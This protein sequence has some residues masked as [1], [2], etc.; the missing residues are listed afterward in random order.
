MAPFT[1]SN[2]SDT[3]PTEVDRLIVENYDG[4]KLKLASNSVTTIMINSTK[5]KIAVDVSQCYLL[6]TIYCERG[7][8]C[9][10]KVPPN[11]EM[12]EASFNPI[13]KLDITNCL[14]LSRLYLDSTHIKH[15]DFT[16]CI[17][18][19]SLVSRNSRLERVINLDSPNMIYIN[20]SYSKL[21][22]I[23]LSR[24]ENLSIL[25][26]NHTRITKLYLD[27]CYGLNKLTMTGTHP[28]CFT[29]PFTVKDVWY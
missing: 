13:K 7:T 28:S 17:H 18:I 4:G 8:V 26:C 19:K 10:L 9:A 23:D 2:S 29:L 3:I 24:C 12:I 22:A 6:K 27:Q 11:I 25:A 20:V 16:G 1:L 21:K 5:R 15:L 14:A